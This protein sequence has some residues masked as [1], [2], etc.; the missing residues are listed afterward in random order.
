MLGKSSHFIHK[1]QFPVW[2]LADASYIFFVFFYCS[3]ITVVLIPQPPLLS[4]A[5][6][7]PHLPHSILPPL[8][9]STCPLCLFLDLTLPLLS[10]V[11]LLLLPLWS[12]SVC[13]LF[14]CLWFYF[15]HLFVLLIRFHL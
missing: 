2:S 11:T 14:P 12:L 13:S 5:L 6:H 4:P 15:A 7:T 9:L 1:F 3:S 8:S 10:S